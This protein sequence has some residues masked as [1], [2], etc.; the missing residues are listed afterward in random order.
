M[1]VP[2]D[3][4]GGGCATDLHHHRLDDLDEESGLFDY[5][6]LGEKRKKAGRQHERIE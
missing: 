5:L 1:L 4:L 3:S 6:L 2:G